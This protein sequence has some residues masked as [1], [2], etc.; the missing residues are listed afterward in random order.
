MPSCLANQ[1]NESSNQN[2]FI[3]KSTSHMYYE[4]LKHY[5]REHIVG[6]CCEIDWRECVTKEI[7]MLVV[8]QT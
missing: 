3:E 5:W 6:L 4:H 1:M 8:R 7:E 2:Y